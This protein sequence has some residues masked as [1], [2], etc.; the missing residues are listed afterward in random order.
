VY[1]H[2]PSV[3]SKRRDI[4]AFASSMGCRTP[5]V[6]DFSRT[7][8]APFV[9][10]HR[11]RPR[12]LRSREVT[13]V[14]TNDGLSHAV[15][16]ALFVDHYTPV[17]RHKGGG[18]TRAREGNHLPRDDH[19][20]SDVPRARHGHRDLRIPR[21]ERWVGPGGGGTTHHRGAIASF[22][23][24]RR[25]LRPVRTFYQ[26]HVKDLWY[27]LERTAL[28]RLKD[29]KVPISRRTKA[30]RRRRLVDPRW[31]RRQICGSGR[32]A[33]SLLRAAPSRIHGSRTAARND[34]VVRHRSVEVALVARHRRGGSRIFKDESLF[35][36]PTTATRALPRQSWSL[37]ETGPRALIGSVPRNAR[38]PSTRAAPVLRREG[39][40]PAKAVSNAE[41]R[42]TRLAR[43]PV[44][45]HRAHKGW[46]VHH[47]S[48]K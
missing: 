39:R 2:A 23:Q 6:V 22:V 10:R 20:Q 27:V 5:I 37:H 40:A 43:H 44:A 48:V 7:A 30:A 29:G 38:P 11:R 1:R 14:A 3:R 28:L 42:I 12:A 45:G 31:R 4:T 15:V 35:H 36:E 17:D 25:P 16:L 26:R 33:G 41:R 46:C 18:R 24:R 13:P 47:T 32:S 34:I 21:R 9:D 19:S 8:T